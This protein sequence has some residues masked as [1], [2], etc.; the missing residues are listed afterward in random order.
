VTVLEAKLTGFRP[1]NEQSQKRA[2]TVVEFKKALK[3]LKLT[4]QR[5]LFLL[6]Y[7]S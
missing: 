2:D 6:G 3:N 5:V 1:A 7:F 4:V